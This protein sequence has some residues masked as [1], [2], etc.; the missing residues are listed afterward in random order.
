MRAGCEKIIEKEV[1]DRQKDETNDDKE[2]RVL[3]GQEAMDE[4]RGDMEAEAS[5][6]YGR[7]SLWFGRIVNHPSRE[8]RNLYYAFHAARDWDLGH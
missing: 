4:H 8:G 7:P 6:V 1:A 3:Q 2:L 5:F